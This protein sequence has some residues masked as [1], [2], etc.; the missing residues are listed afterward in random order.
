MVREIYKSDNQRVMEIYK[1]G[2]ETRN[3]TFVTFAP[4]WY[5]WDLKHIKLS[6]DVRLE[7]AI[8]S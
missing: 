8:V 1:S 7:V 5:E 2:L 6:D 4:H 3:A